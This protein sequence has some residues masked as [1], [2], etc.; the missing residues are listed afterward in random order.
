MDR[1][2]VADPDNFGMDPDPT[3]EQL[4]NVYL[5]VLIILLYT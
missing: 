5:Y 1:S 4:T 2:S 3:S